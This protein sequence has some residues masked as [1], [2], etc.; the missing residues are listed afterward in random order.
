MG[1]WQSRSIPSIHHLFAPLSQSTSSLS[2]LFHVNVRVAVLSSSSLACCSFTACDVPGDLV[3]SATPS[4]CTSGA[5]DSATRTLLRRHAHSLI[6]ASFCHVGCGRDWISSPSGSGAELRTYKGRHQR[7]PQSIKRS[8]SGPDLSGDLHRYAAARHLLKPACFSKAWIP[9][10]PT[11]AV[12][13]QQAHIVR[14]PQ[15]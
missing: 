9:G 8:T 12:A 6:E 3:S 1:E 2:Q 15:T 11:G 10:T 7:H 4:P 14:F 5:D 13:V